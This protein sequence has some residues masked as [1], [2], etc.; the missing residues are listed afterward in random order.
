MP[1]LLYHKQPAPLVAAET[2][3]SITSTLKDIPFSSPRTQSRDRTCTD[4]QKQTSN[5][6]IR[7]LSEQASESA[8]G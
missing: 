2:K 8:Q 3:K 7:Y 4:I 1:P 5:L 6:A